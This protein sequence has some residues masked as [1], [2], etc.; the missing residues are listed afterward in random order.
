MIKSQITK[1]IAQPTGVA[2]VS[3]VVASQPLPMLANSCVKEFISHK[4]KK[5]KISS[6]EQ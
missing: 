4:N 3:A 6:A 5:Y 2:I 1:Y